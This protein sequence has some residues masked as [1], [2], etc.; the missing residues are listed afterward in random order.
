[1]TEADPTPKTSRTPNIRQT[2]GDAQPMKANNA[3]NP[4]QHHYI[5]LPSTTEWLR[6]SAERGN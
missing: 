3:K 2:T 6:K 5:N 1:M 4:L